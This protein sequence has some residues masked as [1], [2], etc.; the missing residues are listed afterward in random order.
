MLSKDYNLTS[1]ARHT[2]KANMAV[3]EGVMGLFDGYDGKSDAGSSAQMAKWLNLPVLLVVDAQSMARSAAA[4]VQGFE[5]FDRQLSFV[6]VV[7]NNIGSQ[8]HLAYLK[9]AL[10]E[11]VNMP[12]LGGISRNESI[13]LPERH[14]GLV[15][16]EDYTL[17]VD[18]I[19]R[20]AD[21]IEENLQ[22]DQ[23]LA[24]LPEISTE[25]QI[26]MP[27]KGLPPGCARI[28]VAR[29]RA[30]C[31]YYPDNLEMLQS[32]GAELIDFSPV[33]DR[34]LP[35]NLDGLYLGGGYPELAAKE[36]AENKGLKNQ[37]LQ[38]SHQGM[39]IFSE[40]GGFMYL[41]REIC[42]LDGNRFPMVGCFPFKARMFDR[43]RSLGYREITLLKPAVIGD[44]DLRVRGHEFHYSGIDNGFEENNVDTVFA[45]RA[46]A[47]IQKPT[48]GYQV[49][50]TLGSYIHLHFG[51]RPAVAK[52]FVENCLIYQRER[53]SSS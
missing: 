38:K 47:G 51:S 7:F 21:L 31:F 9:E 44:T 27:E 46:R 11:H 45:A 28:G 37:I 43:L 18:E 53:N 40:C 36:L 3:V 41:C 48:M 8:R 32:Y 23:L 4:L 24:K 19:N 52:N 39:P 13:R 2:C 5:R 25:I 20:L 35:E 30:F 1:F 6:G 17:S 26:P 22:L 14:L 16:R 10:D 33:A 12:C 50:R 42:D 15:T 29:D 49:Q 34:T